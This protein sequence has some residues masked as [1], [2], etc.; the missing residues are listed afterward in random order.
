MKL[1]KNKIL[2]ILIILI[3][4]FLF[5]CGDVIEGRVSIKG[6]EPHTYL[7]IVT[8]EGEEF[9]IVGEL[10]KSISK[11][12]QGNT[13]KVKGKIV[14]KGLGPGFPPQLEVEKIVE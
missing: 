7:S 4:N 3:S 2:F 12:Y 14:Q 6:N 5:F 11:K 10:E 13:I 1:I 8:S 9:R